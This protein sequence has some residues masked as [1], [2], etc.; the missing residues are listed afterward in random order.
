MSGR[1]AGAI[2]PAQAFHDKRARCLGLG[3]RGTHDA[4]TEAPHGSDVRV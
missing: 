4:F 3:R 1:L 2:V